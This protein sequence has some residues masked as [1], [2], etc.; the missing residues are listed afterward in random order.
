MAY[1]RSYIGF[2]GSADLGL[3]ICTAQ[4]GRTLSDSGAKGATAQLREGAVAAES[5]A[6]GYLVP[7]DVQGPATGGVRCVRAIGAADRAASVNGQLHI[8]SL[9]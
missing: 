5:L 3:Q 1:S 9:P 4:K 2:S 8:Q 6:V 7:V